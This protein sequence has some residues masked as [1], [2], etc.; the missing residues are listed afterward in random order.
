MAPSSRTR[1]RFSLC[2]AVPTSQLVPNLSPTISP[3]WTCPRPRVLRPRP[4]PRAP[5][6]P[7]ALLAHLLS[8]IC[9]LCPALSPYLSLCPHEPRTSATVHRRPPPVPWP[10]LRPRPVQCHG[11]LRLAVSYS[12]HPSVCPLPLWSVRSTLT[13]VVLAQPELRHRR[14]VASLCLRRCPVPPTLALKV[15][16]LP[17]PLLPCILHWLSRNCSPELPR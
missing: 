16:N 8:S 7:R 15:S 11:E 14:P 2:P 13:G 12:G 5:F 4:R 17:A 3:S 9:A 10:P 1:A 6:E